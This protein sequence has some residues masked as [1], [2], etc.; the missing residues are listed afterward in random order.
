MSNKHIQHN[1]LQTQV[2]IPTAHVLPSCTII[3]HYLVDTIFY[4]RYYYNKFLDGLHASIIVIFTYSP[5]RIQSSSFNMLVRSWHYCTHS[6]FVFHFIQSKTKV[7]QWHISLDD[8]EHATSL[9]SSP[10]L[11]LLCSS[12]IGL[13]VI[14]WTLQTYPPNTSQSLC[15]C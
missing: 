2:L 5:F 9:I 1:M 12:H 15:P 6:L 11:C 8:L 10:P 13:F 14:L 4:C 7:L 3:C